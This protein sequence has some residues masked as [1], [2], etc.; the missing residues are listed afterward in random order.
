MQA[1]ALDCLIATF[2]ASSVAGAAGIRPRNETHKPAPKKRSANAEQKPFGIE[3]DPARVARTIEIR[4]T[5]Q[6]RF[7][8]SVITVKRV[9]R[10][11]SCTGT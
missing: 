7:E 5:D 11:V 6:M 3:G 2:L 4:M 8:P 1:H 9:R 10:S